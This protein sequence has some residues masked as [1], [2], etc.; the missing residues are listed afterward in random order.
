MKPFKKVGCYALI[1]IAVI[2]IIFSVGK[3]RN[4]AEDK[5]NKIAIENEINKYGEPAEKIF[6]DSFD[7][8]DY[9][10]VKEYFN[11]KENLEYKDGNNIVKVWF[12]SGHYE[13]HVSFDSNNLKN[14]ARLLQYRYN[15]N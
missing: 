4:I 6:A 5:K 13:V 10:S 3:Y 12:L 2:L 14:Q 15:S 9:N 8:K 1:V 11:K 7:K